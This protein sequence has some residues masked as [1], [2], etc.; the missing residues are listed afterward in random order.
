MLVLLTRWFGENSNM[1]SACTGGLIVMVQYHHALHLRI[2]TSLDTI[3]Y[4][5][6]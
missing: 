6:E 2:I 4:I 1:E 3:N 5:Y